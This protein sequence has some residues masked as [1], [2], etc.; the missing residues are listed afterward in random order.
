[1]PVIFKPITPEAFKI[2]GFNAELKKQLQPVANGMERDYRKGFQTWSNAS[3]PEVKVEL[4]INIF[5]GVSITI[6]I[7]GQIYE[8]VHDG[9]RP[10]RISIRRARRLVFQRGY[11]AKTQP[12][13]IAARA[14]GPFG[15]VVHA[16]T[17][18]HPGY[19]GRKFTTPIVQKWRPAFERGAQRGLDYGAKKSG[20]AI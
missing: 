16:I 11:R 2:D 3:K 4:V 15:D 13:I 17:V 18:Q 7:I 8:F 6:D 1:M 9:V 10:H 19:P 14:G 12:G 20:H 5:G